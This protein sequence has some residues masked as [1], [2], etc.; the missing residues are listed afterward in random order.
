MTNPEGYNWLSEED[1]DK[2]IGQ[3]RMALGGIMSPLD[4]YGNKEYVTMAIEAIIKL[5][6]IFG[7]KVR[8]KD[9]PYIID[10][11]FEHYRADD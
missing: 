3:L 4:K 6:E 8:G 10:S 5:A 11:R 7:Q 2:A 1:Y 9:K